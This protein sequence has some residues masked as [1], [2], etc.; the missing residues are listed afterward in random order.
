MNLHEKLTDETFRSDIAPL[1][2][3]NVVWS[4]GDAAAFLQREILPLVP[5]EPWK[6]RE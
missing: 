4:I 2:A 3:P 1:V 6:G 5:G